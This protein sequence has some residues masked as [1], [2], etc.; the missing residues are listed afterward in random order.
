M[1]SRF[2]RSLPRKPARAGPDPGIPSLSVLTT[3]VIGGESRS[4]D[5]GAEDETAG[6]IVRR[7][8]YSSSIGGSRGSRSECRTESQPLHS[9]TGSAGYF[10][11]HGSMSD[12]LQRKKTEP[13]S[14]RMVSTCPH[15]AHRPGPTSGTMPQFD[16]AAEGL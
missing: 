13:R 5:L 12:N 8:G 14:E 6:R 9:I 2:H 3:T 15:V 16:M 4:G 7:R 10:G 11:K 1:A